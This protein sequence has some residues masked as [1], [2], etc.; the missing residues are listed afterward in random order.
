MQETTT[1]KEEG[2]KGQGRWRELENT[3]DEVT[4]ELKLENK[5]KLGKGIEELQGSD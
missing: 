5:H 2:S 1:L 4:R 3:N